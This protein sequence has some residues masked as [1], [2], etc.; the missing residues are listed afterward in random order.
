MPPFRN[1]TQRFIERLRREGRGPEA[2]AAEAAYQNALASGSSPRETFAAAEAAVQIVT[3][4]TARTIRQAL[5][6]TGQVSIMPFP[7]S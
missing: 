3:M 1:R 4:E 2:A 6:A 5:A 7:T